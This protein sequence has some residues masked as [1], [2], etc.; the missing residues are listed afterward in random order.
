MVAIAFMPFVSMGS[1]D[2]NDIKD[3]NLTENIQSS[4]NDNDWQPIGVMEISKKVGN[5]VPATQKVQVYKNSDGTR[6][7]KDKYGYHELRDN[8]MYG[9]Q[10]S[11]CFP[12]DY[13][14]C[15][16]YQ[17]DEWY[18]QGIVKQA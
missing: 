11:G 3:G 13:R 16:S 2:N 7:V 18:T 15:V 6:A 4:S 10:L 9:R 5:N 8:P 1:N 14:Y 17:G 12:C